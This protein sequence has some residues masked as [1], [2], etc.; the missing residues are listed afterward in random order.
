MARA[1]ASCAAV[2]R[3]NGSVVAI[4]LGADSKELLIGRAAGPQ[5]QRLIREVIESQPGVDALLE[6][7]T[8]H[9]GPDSL[10]V[11]ARVDLNDTV[12]ASQAED[13]ADE[14]DRRLSEE[15]PLQPHVFIDP[16]PAP[17][18]SDR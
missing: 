6:L 3:R 11:G 4:K 17:L 7:R 1:R 8:M 13:L 10:I 14:I 15:L 18:P 9:M 16:T 2:K 5:I 12:G